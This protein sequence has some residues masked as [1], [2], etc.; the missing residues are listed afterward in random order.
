MSKQR[1]NRTFRM[2]QIPSH[3]DERGLSQLL[4]SIS[5]DLGSQNDLRIHS[6]ASSLNPSEHPPT[7]TATVTYK[8]LPANFNPELSEWKLPT[9]DRHQPSDIIVDVH[10]EGFTALN[11]VSGEHILEYDI[12]KATH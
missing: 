6:L 8:H 9:R 4:A 5:E 7:K 11:D 3:L 2:R 10:F 12:P 1:E